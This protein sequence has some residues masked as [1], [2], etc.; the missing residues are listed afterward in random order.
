MREDLEHSS[1]ERPR[2]DA[3][4]IHWSDEFKL[5][6]EEED[7]DLPERYEDID[8]ELKDLQND[9]EEALDEVKGMKNR[10]SNQRIVTKKDE[11]FC[12]NVRKQMRND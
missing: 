9:W 8:K 10:I 4:R 1:N 6:Q 12:A 11:L 7:Y 3:S 5:Y 2:K